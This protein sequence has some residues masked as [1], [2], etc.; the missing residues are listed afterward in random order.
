MSDQH[1][2]PSQPPGPPPLGRPTSR[3]RKTWILVAAGVGVLVLLIVGVL[4]GDDDQDQAATRAGTTAGTAAPTSAPVTEPEETTP[5]PTEPEVGRV[6]TTVDLEDAD[7]P[8]GKITVTQVRAELRDPDPYTSER[9]KR[10]RFL[11]VSVTARAVN[12]G[13]TINPYDFYAR[14]Q[15]SGTHIEEQCC[16]DF[17]AELDAVTLNDGEETSGVMV[18][19]VRQGKVHLVYAPNFDEEPIAEWRIA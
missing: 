15:G 5:P 1:S 13:F 16:A 17:G 7:G 4:V 6:G 2:Q 12:D 8:L 19:D 9:A 10:G 11:V 18:F 14:E 3:N